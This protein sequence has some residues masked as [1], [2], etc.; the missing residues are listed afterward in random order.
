MNQQNKNHLNIIS[1]I[2]GRV[3]LKTNLLYKNYPLAQELQKLSRLKEISKVDINLYSKSILILYN[4]EKI[5]LK[6]I[7]EELNQLLIG[8]KTLLKERNQLIKNSACAIE[9]NQRLNH[10]IKDESPCLNNEW[11]QLSKQKI[12]NNLNTNLKDGLSTKRALTILKKKGLNK[13]KEDKKRSFF[14]F[15]FAQFNDFIT[16]LLLGAGGISL[17]LGQVG[18]AITIV[19]I[20]VIEALLGAWQEYNAE[21]SLNTLKKHSTSKTK[22]IRDGKRKEVYS[23]NIVP[24]DIIIFEAGNVIPADARLIESSKLRI[25]EATL[26]GESEPITK[27]H[28]I[29]YASQ[30]PLGDRKNMV[31]MGTKIVKGRGRAIVVETGMQTKMGQIAGLIKEKKDESTPLQKDL[32][33]LGKK[34]SWG[35][36]TICSGIILSGLLSGQPFWQILKTGISLAIGAIPEGLATVLSISLAFGVKRMAKKGAIIKQLPVT[37]TLS[38]ADVICTDKTGTLTTGQMTVTDIFTIKNNYK[39]SGRGHSTTG[40]IYCNNEIISINDHNELKETL[41]IGSL[42]NN[43]SCN[44]KNSSCKSNLNIVGDPTESALK[45]VANKANLDTNSFDCYIREKEIAFDSETKKMT[46]ICK[47]PDNKYSI[48]VKGAP[49]IILKQCTKIL[50]GNEVR[51]LTSKDIKEIEDAID[52]MADDALRVIGF[53]YKKVDYNPNCDYIIKENLIFTGLAGLIDPPKEDVET[54]IN[55][56]HQAGIKVVMITGDHKKTA[57]AIA[58]KI[59]ILNSDEKVLTGKELDMLTDKELL[60]IIDE[61][62]VFARTSPYQKLR[63]VK[64]LKAKGHIVAMTGDGVNDAPAIKEANIGIAMGAKGSEVTQ[65]SSSI[66]LTDDNFTTIVDAIEEGRGVS[67]NIQL[68]LKY[69][70]AG[71][72]G[73]T[74]A[75]FLAALAGMPTPM[76]ASQILLF[77][78]ITEGFPALSLGMEPANKDNMKR[79]PRDANKSIFNSN[80]LQN[81]MVKGLLIGLSTMGLYTTTYFLTNDILKASTLTYAN[82]VLNQLFHLLD[83]RKSPVNNNKFL[84]PSIIA[85]SS[86]LLGS[87]YIRPLN[88]VFRTSPLNLYDWSILLITSG[89]LGR[90]DYFKDKAERLINNK[91]LILNQEGKNIIP[92]TN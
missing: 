29:N 54:A 51:E 18:D 64:A 53:A 8:Y 19:S 88:T 71:N 45:I 11:Y 40:D 57:Q 61:V 28:K 17:F 58:K 31:F 66:V 65:Q 13:F 77:D 26:T 6:E 52:K 75:I 92:V 42:C 21:E 76:I 38:C 33:N 90:L 84:I 34:I 25:D 15:F 43:A 86:L 50:D 80:L 2:P 63:I 5:T 56:C 27:S 67:D 70:L 22:V 30:I 89:F 16:K 47:D 39:V 37:E 79:P 91:N 60:E 59:N 41:T 48:N 12:V 62:T 35:C 20:T 46:V 4:S 49:D 10:S 74:L 36:L 87:I 14:S 85:S 83:C 9:G 3:R 82:L 72:L 1:H 24:G 73:E 23:V 32:E 78:L 69:V 55:K 44:C 7:K 68:F 81:I